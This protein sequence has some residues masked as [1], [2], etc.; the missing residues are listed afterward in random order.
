MMSS[1]EGQKFGESD[2]EE[3]RDMLFPN[4]RASRKK[5]VEFRKFI[6]RRGGIK[7]VASVSRIIDRLHGDG[8]GFENFNDFE[9]F[10]KAMWQGGNES[11]SYDTAY[12]KRRII[13]KLQQSKA[14]SPRMVG[15]VNALN[16]D[17]EWRVRLNR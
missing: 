3:I 5:S 17:V 12:V 13:K 11:D 2:I 1:I 14:F 15:I 9:A 6:A 10:Y 8:L 4:L 7:D 16:L